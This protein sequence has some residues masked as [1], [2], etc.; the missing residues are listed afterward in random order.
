VT[1][2]I[3]EFRPPKKIVKLV[4]TNVLI[5]W[6]CDVCGGCT[7]KVEI[8]AESDDGFRI[9]EACLKEG[10]FDAK[11]RERAAFLERRAVHLRGL[12]GKIKAPAYADWELAMAEF[13][14]ERGSGDWRE[15]SAQPPADD[16]PGP[17]YDDVS[18]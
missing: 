18:F 5:R 10:D 7:E 9:C 3:I 6:P 15:E 12:V 11:L 14:D 1:Y 13:Y 17:I 16:R 4:R 8:L 2:N